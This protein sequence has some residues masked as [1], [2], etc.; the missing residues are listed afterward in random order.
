M[1]IAGPPSTCCITGVR[2][3][4]EPSGSIKQI[5]QI[6]TY[7]AY[8]EN[9]ST[10]KAILFLTDAFGHVFQNNKLVADDFA[11]NG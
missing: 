10:D 5:G 3:S 11:K 1:S 7:F 6:E 2:H 4:G 9:N 8:P